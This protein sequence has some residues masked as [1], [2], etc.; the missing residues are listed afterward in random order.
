MA[1]FRS[2]GSFLVLEEEPKNA[3]AI[4]VLSGGSDKAMMFHRQLYFS[5]FEQTIDVTF[6]SP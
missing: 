3:D 6:V 2:A 4:I 5:Y 1:I